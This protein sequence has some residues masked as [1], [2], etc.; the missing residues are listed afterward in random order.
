[1]AVTRHW[2]R[3]SEEVLS[4]CKKLFGKTM[5]SRRRRE[6]RAGH[7]VNTL[8]QQAAYQAA[9][10][11]RDPY[12]ADPYRPSSCPF[13]SSLGRAEAGGCGLGDHRPSHKAPGA[14]PARYGAS[15]PTRMCVCTLRGHLL[16]A[17]G[18]SCSRPNVTAL[19]HP[20]IHHKELSFRVQRT[21]QWLQIMGTAGPAPLR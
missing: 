15:R 12:L 3:E 11:S 9:Q 14:D 1:M 5:V 7:K 10:A 2:D 8:G 20:H 4:G 16:A 6:Q 18:A 13:L 17:T 19:E 21:G